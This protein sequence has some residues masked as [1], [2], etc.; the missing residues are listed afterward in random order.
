MTMA[1][2]G[3]DYFASGV[4]LLIASLRSDLYITQF[5]TVNTPVY[6]I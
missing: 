6:F 4:K 5:S 1:H 3:V 2:G